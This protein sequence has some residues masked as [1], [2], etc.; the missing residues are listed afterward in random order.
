MKKKQKLIIKRRIIQASVSV[1]IVV[2]VLV[3]GYFLYKNFVKPNN[4]LIE[5][6][7]YGFKLQTPKHW[8]AIEKIAYSED[9]ITKILAKCK[10]G[11]EISEMGAFR[12]ES[13]IYPED[14]A[15]LGSAVEAS[16]CL[17][18]G[19][20]FEV[21]VNCVPDS[22]KNKIESITGSLSIAG[23]KASKEVFDSPQFGKTTQISLLHD[24]LQ[25]KINGYVYVSPKDK[26]NENKLRQNYACAFNKIIS[27]FKFL[28]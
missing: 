18:S 4:Y 10:N 20:I 6:S 23:E 27:S 3:A 25:Y 1:V 24:N 14:L 5:N 15:S 28:K 26:A 9:N 21:S 7:Y 17:S 2:L 19:S 16:A 13:L 8:T 12:F 22:M 11:K